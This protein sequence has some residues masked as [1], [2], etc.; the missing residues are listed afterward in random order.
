M[1]IHKMIQIFKAGGGVTFQVS[2][3]FDSSDVGIENY[4]N[5]SI[6][7]RDVYSTLHLL[8]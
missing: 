1:V 4:F 8:L 3:C 7:S 6:D 5:E 2:I